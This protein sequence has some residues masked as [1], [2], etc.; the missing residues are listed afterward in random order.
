MAENGVRLRMRAM[1]LSILFS[2]FP[3]LQH[4]NY[5][6]PHASSQ[7]AD[8]AF[9]SLQCLQ[10]PNQNQQGGRTFNHDDG[11]FSFIDEKAVVK[12]V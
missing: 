4:M 1:G 3:Y 2:T 10:T 5:R 12:E 8:A 11:S 7:E 6:F 9:T